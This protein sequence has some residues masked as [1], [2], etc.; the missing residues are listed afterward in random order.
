MT[1]R[2]RER[3]HAHHMSNLSMAPR[4]EKIWGVTSYFNFADY[5]TKLKNFRLFRASLQKQ[6]LPLVV[7]EAALP[8]A[9]F[10]LN[11][12][13]ADILI[14]RRAHA[15]LWQK[16]RLLNIGMDAL[17][18]QC[19]AV[20]WLDNDS[21]FM[22]ADW[23]RKTSDL[24]THYAV[25]QPFGELR[26]L[27]RGYLPPSAGEP[28]PLLEY[29]YHSAMYQAVLDGKM[30]RIEGAPGFAIAARRTVIDAC[31]LY[32]KMI[33]GG[34]DAL[35]LGACMG[36]PLSNINYIGFLP[37]ALRA[38]AESWWHHMHS[39]VQG[40]ISC[41]PGTA[42]HL[43]HGTLSNRYYLHRQWLLAEFDPTT[44]IAIDEQGCWR[45]SSEKPEL[46]ERVR[47][48]FFVRK[49]DEDI[50]T[51]TDNDLSLSMA[52]VQIR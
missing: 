21:V 23:V 38:D 30:V 5:Q 47:R 6:G 41:L 44:D 12:D 1:E 45:W 28:E 18:P 39:I 16:E 15:V 31:R 2:K 49:E 19:E 48:Y 46:H 10:V 42:Y 33:L 52:N 40:S 25:V 14:Q 34:A 32:D 8:G 20:V 29:A 50:P 27:E 51:A 9:S 35:I 17:P 11:A 36:I 26:R 13:D 3:Y 37:D 4:Q 24:L 43:W 22:D 7:V